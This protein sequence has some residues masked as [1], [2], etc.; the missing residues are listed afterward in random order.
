[1][2]NPRKCEN[3]LQSFQKW[4]S[5]R[6]QANNQLI[7]W[8]GAFTLSASVRRKIYL[9]KDYLGGWTCYPHLYVMFVGPP[10]TMK[11]TTMN[12]SM[13]LLAQCPDIVQSPT[14]TNITALT[15][16][17]LKSPDSSIY[18]TVEEFGDIILKGSD[19]MYEFLTSMY[20]GKRHIEQKT[21]IRGVEFIAA[22]C[23]NMIAATTPKW[24]AERMPAV[25]IGGGF[26]S[27]VMFIYVPKTARVDRK[28]IYHKDLGNM[29]D[30][31]EI[32]EL[33]RDLVHDISHISRTLDGSFKI[34]N[35]ETMK[36]M[37]DW[38]NQ[39]EDSGNDKLQNY[40]V[41]KHVHALKLS[42]LLRISYSDE[43]VITKDDFDAAVKIVELTEK[44]LPKVFS[45]V[46]KNPYSFDVQDIVQFVLLNPGVKYQD[47]LKQFQ[48]VATPNVLNE[49]IDGSLL[50][51][52]IKTEI[53]DKKE[54]VFNI[55]DDI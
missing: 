47:L 45:G 4:V 6:T 28:F 34:D 46:G 33:E 48:S 9:G 26:A 52:L 41:R 20:D 30:M 42:M 37:D 5:P 49:L 3:F 29:V 12:F 50:M 8:A 7:F 35:K 17:L 55:G 27:R 38:Y 19:E 18:M 39:L 21:M 23:I 15:D 10:G 53:N 14:I 2:P 44:E 31:K 32:D 1:M 13:D 51:G 22:P 36:Y 24:I 54:R 25:A 43:L 11:T 16:S 40:L